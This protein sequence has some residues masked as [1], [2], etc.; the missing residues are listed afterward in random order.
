MVTIKYNGNI[1]N[2]FI[3]YLV[4][5][6]IAKK[7]NLKYVA[8]FPI[9]T[10]SIKIINHNNEFVGDNFIHVSDENWL[11][12]VM[13][14]IK[15][16]SPR[17]HVDGYF[18]DKIFFETYEKEL[19]KNMLITY[20]ESIKEDY[21]MVN[22]RIGDIADDRRMLPLEYYYEALD[23]ITFTKGFITSDSLNHKFCLDLIEKYNLTPVHLN[24]SDTLGYCKNFNKLVLS[25]GGFSWAIGFLSKAKEIICSGRHSG[26]RTHIWHGD[27]YFEKWKK[28]YWDYDP[29]TVYDRYLLNGYKPIRLNEDDL[30]FTNS[31]GTIRIEK[32]II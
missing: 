26:G 28:L 15:Y 17:F 7:Y 19:K 23:S 2:N 4:G 21:V 30:V 11:D 32:K 5:L 22:Y 12:I 14:D 25:E 8:N 3:Q 1:S 16:D 24:P 6:F 13:G 18:N 29:T 9:K 10:E 20:D 31:D 27:I